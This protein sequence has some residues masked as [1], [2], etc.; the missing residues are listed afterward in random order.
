[1]MG[2]YRAQVG[3]AF[4]A[5]A[6]G[7]APY[8]D[9]RMT[10]YLDG[11]EDWILVASTKL[12]KRPDIAVSLSD[13]QFQLEVITRFW[14]PVFA[15]DL[16]AE[17]REV[18]KELLLARN[19][20]AH[21]SE[22][23]PMD[24]PFAERVHDLAGYLLEGVGSPVAAQVD[25]LLDRLR[26]EAIQEVAETE[27]VDDNT[28]LMMRLGKLEDD[29]A[30]LSRQL[31]SAREQAASQTGRTRAVARQLAELQTQYA[32]VAGLK[33]R[34]DRLQVQLEAAAGTGDPER[35]VAQL[36]HA[37]RAAVALRVEST[38]LHE[39]L[40]EARMMLEDPVA[41]E[42]GQRVIWLM[43]ALLVTLSMVMVM[44]TTW[45]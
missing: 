13:P 6:E 9:K 23:Q 10:A 31:D 41:T 34:Y 2:G 14:G 8:V 30:E 19:H 26:W 22:T 7:L 40:A 32:A 24:L 1:M 17:L 38:A 33:D 3:M 5:I 18:V 37:R 4:E 28:A 45:L 29:R 42:V 12:G 27:N 44:V 35:V 21:M 11:G 15:K 39:Q 36:E 43:A 25:E 16:T 20:W